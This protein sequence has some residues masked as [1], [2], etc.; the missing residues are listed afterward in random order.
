MFLPQTLCL[1]SSL[2]LL[3]L[4]PLLA[5]NLSMMI[6]WMMLPIILHLFLYFFNVSDMCDLMSI[7]TISLPTIHRHVTSSDFYQCAWHI[8]RPRWNL[9]LHTQD[10]PKTLSSSDVLTSL[11][12]PLY[13]SGYHWVH[14]VICIWLTEWKR[15]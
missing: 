15:R 12:P 1:D 6:S 13:C 7:Y 2:C 11:H 14:E 10:F 3:I 8:S 9:N 4:F 5:Y